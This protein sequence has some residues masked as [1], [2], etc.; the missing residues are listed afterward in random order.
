MAGCRQKGESLEGPDEFSFVCSRHRI[1]IRRGAV[2]ESIHPYLSLLPLSRLPQA[3]AATAR[4]SLLN[5]THVQYVSFSC[6]L[7]STSTANSRA[8]CFNLLLPV[9]QTRSTHLFNSSRF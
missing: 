6:L 2:S 8:C 3:K 7:H 4:L 5:N 9:F 1:R